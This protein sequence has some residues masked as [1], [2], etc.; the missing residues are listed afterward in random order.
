[1]ERGGE[2]KWPGAFGADP[3]KMKTLKCGVCQAT[4]MEM[5]YAINARENDTGRTLR[6][7]EV[8][9]V[10]DKIC[11]HN[12]DKYGLMLDDKG[13]V[14]PCRAILLSGSSPLLL[15]ND[16]FQLSSLPRDGRTTTN[17]CVPRAGG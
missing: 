7:V 5:A 4:V 15:T 12:M 14:G 2:L 6:E 10:L 13:Q 11:E 8:V 16:C 3:K 1:M 17:P 9:E